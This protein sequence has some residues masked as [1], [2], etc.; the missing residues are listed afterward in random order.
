MDLTNFGRSLRSNDIKELDDGSYDIFIQGMRELSTDFNINAMILA[1]IDLNDRLSRKDIL[2]DEPNG[3]G[4]IIGHLIGTTLSEYISGKNG[5]SEYMRYKEILPADIKARGAILKRHHSCTCR[6]GNFKD[7][8][9]TNGGSKIGLKSALR[10]QFSMFTIIPVNASEEDVDYFSKHFWL[11]PL[12]GIFFGI[13][14]G[15]SFFLLR[16]IYDGFISA[17]ITIFI[18]HALNRFLHFDGMIDIGDGLIAVGKK[19]KKIAAMK[20]SRVG[21]GGVSF[22]I[23]FSLLLISA[24][25]A[26]PMI[27]FFAPF[28]MEICAKNS[29]MASAAFGDEREGLGSPFVKNTHPKDALFSAAL[30]LLI[31]IPFALIF[32]LPTIGLIQTIILVISIVVASSLLGYIM[33]LIARKHFGSVNG[34]VLGATNEFGKIIA[35]L[36]ILAMI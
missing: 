10:T 22:G 2:G 6:W 19:E 18:L 32:A 35:L 29:L 9:P 17:I 3:N 28:A 12:I 16:E 23:L 11:T 1:A 27:L 33:S 30:C 20:D 5:I 31:L 34:D 4:L 21:A 15:A 25:A 13:I 8:R 26:I 24:L 7:E 14:A 36:I